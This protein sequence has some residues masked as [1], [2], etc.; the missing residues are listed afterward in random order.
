MDSGPK[1]SLCHG[2]HIRVRRMSCRVIEGFTLI[3]RIDRKGN[4]TIPNRVL[5]I[6]RFQRTKA[7]DV[8]RAQRMPY[9]LSGKGQPREPG[10]RDPPDNRHCRLREHSVFN[11][12]QSIEHDFGADIGIEQIQRCVAAQRC[13]RRLEPIDCG[14]SA[15]KDFTRAP[16]D[17][18]QAEQLRRLFAVQHAFPL[19]TRE[20]ALRDTKSLSK[21]PCDTCT[22]LSTDSTA[23]A[24]MPSR[25]ISTQSSGEQGLVSNT[26][27]PPSTFST[28]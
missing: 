19:S 22:A 23:A 1:A 11:A 9:H 25:I 3:H 6:K 17:P 7:R 5:A 26:S 12:P 15:I 28:D 20:S 21:L 24:G 27:F 8:A 2:K 18:S 13:I 16:R 14:G 4:E 10:R